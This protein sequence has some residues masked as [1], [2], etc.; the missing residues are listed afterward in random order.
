MKN[1]L[2]SIAENN[3]SE[4]ELKIKKFNRNAKYAC[5]FGGLGV[6]G[7][8]ASWLAGPES[9]AYIVSGT[10]LG[11]ALGLYVAHL[12]KKAGYKKNN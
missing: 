9:G 10:I 1:S 12:A 2:E 4:A 6:G 8:I 11:G 3:I 5:F 7:S